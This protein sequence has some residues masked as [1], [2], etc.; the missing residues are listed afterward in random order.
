M[1]LERS[2]GETALLGTTFSIEHQ[3][4]RHPPSA[5]SKIFVKRDPR[6]V[7]GRLQSRGKDLERTNGSMKE[8]RLDDG[9][10][11]LARVYYDHSRAHT[12]ERQ[13]H[14][15]RTLNS[16]NHVGREQRTKV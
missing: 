12:E 14:E 7:A 8:R 5:C 9:I 6:S 3:A 10:V 16:D 4:P 13:Q 1:A 15:V 2:Q 11:R